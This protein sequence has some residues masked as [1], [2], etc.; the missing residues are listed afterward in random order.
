MRIPLIITRPRAQAEEFAKEVERVCPGK[1][2]AMISPLLEIRAEPA[3]VDISGAQALLFSSRN[4]VRGFAARSSDR[5]I[6]AICVGDATA[7]EAT[8]LG[9]GATSAGGDV[10]ALATVAAQS[11]LE[12][13]GHMVYFRGA[14]TAGD[15]AGAL[16]GEGI[17]CEE[18]IIYDQF[19]LFLTTEA[20]NALRR[21][22]CAAVVFSPRIASL[23]AD[24]MDGLN[25]RTVTVVAISD[26]TASPL[27]SMANA[28][29]LTANMPNSRAI[30][31]IL[32]NI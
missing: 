27:K 6:P 16:M 15:L 9:F 3:S 10:S 20:R 22:A 18:R 11:Y 7:R 5:S 29:V 8:S 25:P 32:K 2:S 1:Y 14:E 28:K 4:A 23:L 17:P 13:F 31:E 26:N 19:P 30:L 21:D 24:E 12:D